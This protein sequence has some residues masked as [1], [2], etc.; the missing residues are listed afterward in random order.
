MS[1]QKPAFVYHFLNVSFYK[2]HRLANSKGQISEITVGVVS[3][4]PNVFA[5][6]LQ[7][8]KIAAAIAK[9]HAARCGKSTE[10]SGDHHASRSHAEDPHSD[11][12][13]HKPYS[14]GSS[15]NAAE[16]G[17]Q[18]SFHLNAVSWHV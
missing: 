17:F 14:H 12:A 6:A 3:K 7:A 8:C 16:H 11:Q 18:D 2:F 1:L 9:K 10:D 5:A 15:E 13:D 4:C